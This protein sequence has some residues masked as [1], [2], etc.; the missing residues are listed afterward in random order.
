MVPEGIGIG[1]SITLPG[2]TRRQ[3]ERGPRFPATQPTTS[4]VHHS[5][6]NM[7]HPSDHDKWRP[8]HFFCGAKP[9]E[10]RIASH[11]LRTSPKMWD[12][13]PEAFS[14][15]LFYFLACM[16]VK[17]YPV[18]ESQRCFREGKGAYTISTKAA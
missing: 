12:E 7:R 2:I 17:R 6:S 5:T 15:L 14:Y 9:R 10:H 13:L 1:G 8:L 11:R 4:L 18:R 16:G 3:V